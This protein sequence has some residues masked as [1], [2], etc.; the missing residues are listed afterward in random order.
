MR[1]LW[2]DRQNYSHNVS[3][4]VK[5]IRCFSEGSETSGHGVAKVGPFEN[6]RPD[7]QRHTFSEIKFLTNFVR[8]GHLRAKGVAIADRKGLRHPGP[9]RRHPV[10]SPEIAMLR[11]LGPLGCLCRLLRCSL[12][13]FCGLSGG[14]QRCNDCVCV[15]VGVTGN[16]GSLCCMLGCILPGFH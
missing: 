9:L 14:L 10:Y 7:F 3:Q 12:S 16:W 13:C 4:K 5:R 6:G 2:S 1:A 15:R 11:G 8:L